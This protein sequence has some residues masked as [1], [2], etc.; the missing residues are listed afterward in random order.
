MKILPMSHYKL[1]T[2]GFKLVKVSFRRIALLI[3]FVV[4]IA[5]YSGYTFKDTLFPEQNFSQVTMPKKNVELIK[6]GKYVASVNQKL[7]PNEIEAIVN[8]TFK[9]SR[10]YKLDPYMVL[11]L[12]QVESKFDIHAVSNSNALGLTQVIPKWHKEKIKS[13][14]SKFGHFDIF[15]IEHNIALGVLVLHEYRDRDMRKMLKKYGAGT[16]PDYDRLVITAMKEAKRLV[17]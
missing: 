8:N 17:A 2:N 12:M 13:L 7:L 9:Y 4:S 10:E 14:I 15:N 3:M 16:V 11:G 5:L 6:M 1:T